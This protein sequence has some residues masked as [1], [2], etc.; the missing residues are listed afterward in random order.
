MPEFSC[1]PKSRPTPRARK[2]LEAAGA[3]S[4]KFK[5]PRSSFRSI[6]RIGYFYDAQGI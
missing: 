6:V 2:R 1:N 3:V 4:S 5:T